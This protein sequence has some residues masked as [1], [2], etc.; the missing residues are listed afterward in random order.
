LGIGSLASW[1]PEMGDRTFYILLILLGFVS[2][3]GS[4]LGTIGG[5]LLIKEK[6]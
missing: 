5:I 4:I 2:M 6:S 1:R 3:F